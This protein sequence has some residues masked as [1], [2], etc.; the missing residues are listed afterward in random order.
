[1]PVWLW[2]LIGLAVAWA[3]AKYKSSK[4]TSAAATAATSSDTTEGTEAVAPQFV[5]ENN[6][7]TDNL[8]VNTTSTPVQ[9]PTGPN[10]PVVTPPGTAPGPPVATNPDKPPTTGKP[11]VTTKP[12]V[13]V[14]KP[15]VSKKKPPIQYKV[16]HG[17]TLSS[18]ASR[19]HTTVDKLWTYNTTPGVRPADTIATLKS[20][21]KNLL[22]A[23]ETILIP[24]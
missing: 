3:Y 16:V 24:Q 1:M 11:P 5:I 19:Y 9:T 2:A 15:P 6:L 22:F 18:I 20:R 12:P 14:V 10:P 7:P 4:A 17:D 8:T 13:R 21:G 23:G